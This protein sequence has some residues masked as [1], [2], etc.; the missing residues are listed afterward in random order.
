MIVI[1]LL[2]AAVAGGYFLQQQETTPPKRLSGEEAVIS[3]PAPGGKG[4]PVK[5]NVENEKREGTQSNKFE[6]ISK[7]NQIT[8]TEDEKVKKQ[9]ECLQSLLAEI[10]EDQIPEFVGFIQ[11]E[12]GDIVFANL[13]PHCIDKIGANSELL[14]KWIFSTD[15]SS[16]NHRLIGCQGSKLYTL[17]H[18]EDFDAF[19]GSLSEKKRNLLVSGGVGEWTAAFGL[20]KAFQFLDK[21]NIPASDP[22]RLYALQ[23][24]LDFGNPEDIFI[25]MMTQRD[26][27]HKDARMLGAA[28][29]ALA[30]KDVELAARLTKE[31][32]EKKNVSAKILAK[33]VAQRWLRTS[34]RKLSEWAVSLEQGPARDEVAGVIVAGIY[35]STPADALVW[36]NSI[37]DSKIRNETNLK[38]LQHWKKNYPNE[39]ATW[40][41]IH[42]K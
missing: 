38:I 8:G 31:Q 12:C 36:S 26:E 21:W 39:A 18:R 28:A 7:L 3:R 30:S 24:A 14:K 23:T 10:S 17:G 37:S 40:E 42:L 4:H 16:I 5:V 11:E 22:A 19:L 32:I 15:E 34:P 1:P 41:N 35:E 29:F 9:V 27:W 25:Q 13:I 6:W 20:E 33:T 2:S